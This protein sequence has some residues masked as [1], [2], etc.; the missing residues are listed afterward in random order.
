[1]HL[2][3]KLS[4]VYEVLHC[5]LL[6]VTKFHEA[7]SLSHEASHLSWNLKDH[8]CVYM[9]LPLVLILRQVN[10]VHILTLCFSKIQFDIN[11]S[12]MPG[13]PTMQWVLGTLYLWVKL[14]THLHL[15]LK[16]RTHRAIPPHPQNSSCSLLCCN[17]M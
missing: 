7:Q 4:D 10:P 13:Q 5:L 15:V 8:Y 12:H 16:L 9:G 17:T 1:M 3:I 6:G 14:T 2:Y 11:L